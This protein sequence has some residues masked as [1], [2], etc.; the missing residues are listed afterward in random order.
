MFNNKYSDQ[1]YIVGIRSKER[2]VINSFCSENL[3]AITNYVVKKGGTTTDAD[4]IMQ[5][6]ML[7]LFVNVRK[8]DFSLSCKLRTYFFAICKNTWLSLYK[9]RKNEKTLYERMLSLLAEEEPEIDTSIEERR[10]NLYLTCFVLLSPECQ[11]IIKLRLQKIPYD[12][13]SDQLK[14]VSIGAVRNRKYICEEK[15]NNLMKNHKDYK[16]LSNEE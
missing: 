10:L 3:E 4:D 12:E 2:I 11:Q 5:E 6:G 1:E 7:I 8:E 16:N 13:I 15:L 9:S 14:I